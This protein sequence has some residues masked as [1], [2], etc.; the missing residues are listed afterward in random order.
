MHKKMKIVLILILI[1]VFAALDAGYAL[2]PPSQ[3]NE[4][5]SSQDRFKYIIGRLTSDR[6]SIID[7]DRNH[8]AE[9]IL[10]RFA[11]GYLPDIMPYQIQGIAEKV[12]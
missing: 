4:Q 7:D 8:A 12:P 10:R 11:E 3:F 9:K 2:R 5:K 1:A 6:F